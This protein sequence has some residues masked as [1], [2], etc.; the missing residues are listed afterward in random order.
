MTDRLTQLQVCV[1]QVSQFVPPTQSNL[2]NSFQ[3]VK[4]YYSA[5]SYINRAHDFEPLTPTDPK[6]TDPHVQPTAP[7]SQFQADLHELARDLVVKSKQTEVL[8]DSLPGI[9]SSESEQLER[10]K[11]LEKELE[12]AEMERQGVLVE[13]ERLLGKCDELILKVAEAAGEIRREA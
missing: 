2:S 9:G 3:L 6:A 8:I 11:R 13:S 1:D 12:E 10:A 7:P 4:Q 5:L